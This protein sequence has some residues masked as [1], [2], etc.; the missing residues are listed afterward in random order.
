MV[1]EN[2]R[3]FN[4]GI[5]QSKKLPFNREIVYEKIPKELENWTNYIM[6]RKAD[7]NQAATIIE[8]KTRQNVIDASRVSGDEIGMYLK[9]GMLES[10]WDSMP[11]LNLIVDLHGPE[12]V[13]ATKYAEIIK[14]EFIE[15]DLYKERTY[16]VNNKKLPLKKGLVSYQSRLTRDELYTIFEY[17]VG[18]IPASPNKFTALLRHRGIQIETIRDGST[19]TRGIYVQWIIEEKRLSE[20][21]AQI[22]ASG[23]KPLTLI[24]KAKT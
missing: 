12:S 10:M 16:M 9:K 23:P 3:R 13:F 8:N 18:N 20:I 5:F 15:A 7:I 6:T 21:V 4:F 17:C 24:K 22:K 2:D 11:D 19:T 14:Q 1:D